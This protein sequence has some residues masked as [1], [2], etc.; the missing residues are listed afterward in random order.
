MVVMSIRSG[1][2]NSYQVR[3]LDSENGRKG[4]FL[5]VLGCG[6]RFAFRGRRLACCW[7]GCLDKS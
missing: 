1:Y 7:V 5:V 4:R 2:N 3:I 6:T